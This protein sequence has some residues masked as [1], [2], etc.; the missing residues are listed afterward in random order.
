MGSEKTEHFGK[1]GSTGRSRGSDTRLTGTEPINSGDEHN[2]GNNKSALT[3]ATNSN[4]DT[5]QSPGDH[6]PENV[7]GSAPQSNPA[8]AIP[9]ASPTR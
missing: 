6:I 5:A 3:R 9:P 1:S 7:P 2:S 8:T 4:R